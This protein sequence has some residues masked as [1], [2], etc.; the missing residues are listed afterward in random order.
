MRFFM[1]DIKYFIGCYP[2]MAF[3]TD[4]KSTLY[5]HCV[6]MAV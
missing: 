3:S 1:Q 2:K 6:Y 4:T 5:K